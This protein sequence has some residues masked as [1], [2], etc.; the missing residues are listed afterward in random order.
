[1]APLR[2]DD[3]DATLYSVGQVAAILQVTQAFLRRLDEHA[4]V[5]PSRSAGG[6]RRYSRRQIAA[7]ARARD[8]AGERLTLAAVRRVLALEDRISQLEADLDAAR[9]ET[10]SRRTELAAAKASAADARPAG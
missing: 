5:C 1:M 10:A 2:I 3:Q 9:A 6:Q 7:A 4:V 8:L